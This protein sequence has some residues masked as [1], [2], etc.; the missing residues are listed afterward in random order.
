[1]EKTI[2]KGIL[3]VI[4][5]SLVVPLTFSEEYDYIS[6]KIFNSNDCFV[7]SDNGDTWSPAINPC[8]TCIG[9][10]SYDIGM[11]DGDGSEADQLRKACELPVVSPPLITVDP[12]VSPGDESVDLCP[13]SEGIYEGCPCIMNQNC[14]SDAKYEKFCSNGICEQ[15]LKSEYLE[16]EGSSFADCLTDEFITDKCTCYDSGNINCLDFDQKACFSETCDTE[17]GIVECPPD[18]DC[19]EWGDCVELWSCTPT[20]ICVDGFQSQECVDKAGCEEPQNVPKEIIPCSGQEPPIEEPDCVE[21]T[22]FGTDGKTCYHIKPPECVKNPI[23]VCACVDSS[24][25]SQD[26]DDLTWR[27]CGGACVVTECDDT[28]F[29]REGHNSDSCYTFELNIQTSICE[30]KKV[31][32]SN[33]RGVEG[34]GEC[35]GDAIE[36]GL[37]FCPDIPEECDK[38]GPYRSGNNEYNCYVQEVEDLCEPK[39][40]SVSD[41]LGTMGSGDCEDP[42]FLNQP[43]SGCEKT[44]TDGDGIDDSID[45]CP[46]EGSIGEVDDYGCPCSVEKCDDGNSCTK[47]RC[48]AGKCVYDNIAGSCGEHV[49]CPADTCSTSAPYEFLDYPESGQGQCQAGVC[50]EVN[51]E[52]LSSK[53][54]EECETCQEE[55]EVCDGKDN[56]CNGETDEDLSRQ[57]GS[58]SLGICSFGSETCNDGKWVGCSASFPTQEVC[59]GVDNDCDGAEDNGAGCVCRDGDKKECGISEGACE[60]GEQ[61][62]INGEDWSGCRGGI[63]P[64]LEICDGI[65]NDC[66]GLLDENT[67]EEGSNSIIEQCSINSC[68]GEKFCGLETC[69]LFDDEDSDNLCSE[70]DNCPIDYNPNQEDSDLDGLGNACDFCKND[71]DNDLDNDGV[72]GDQDNC[73]NIANSIQEDSDFDGLG[74]ICDSCVNDPHNDV[75][76]DSICGNLDNCP[77][78]NNPSQGDCDFDG[79]GDACDI[80]SSCSTDSDDDGIMDYYDN[81]PESY[82]FNQDDSD[83]D[84]IG[85]RCDP[86]VNDKYNDVDK[87]GVS[88]EIDNCPLI[89]NE[90]QQ[91]T[92]IDGIGDICDTCDRDKEN[93]RDADNF[94][95]NVD[96]CPDHHNPSQGDCDKDN[97]GD[98]CDFDSICSLDSDKDGINDANDNCPSISNSGQI[99]SDKDNIGDVCD[100]CPKDSFNDQDNDGICGNNDNCPGVLNSN[101]EDKDGDSIGDSCDFCIND[102]QNDID[103]DHICADQDNCVFKAN[104]SQ[105]DC[106]ED[107]LGDACDFDSKCATDKDAD[108][109][110]DLFDNCPENYNP[111]QLDKDGDSI[112][113][114]CDVCPNDPS[115]DLDND[116]S[117][118]DI[119]NCPTVGNLNQL[120]SD[121]DGFGDACDKCPFDTENDLDKDNICG[122]NDNCRYKHNPNQKDCDSNEIGDA[123]DFDSACVEDSDGDGIID[124]EDNCATISNQDQK[125]DDM[126]KIG[127]ACDI[128]PIDILNDLDLDSVCGNNDNCPTLFNPT[129]SN[130]DFDRFGDKCDLCPNDENNDI[131][132]DGICGDVDTC[133]EIKNPNQEE[134][135]KKIEIKEEKYDEEI[136][137]TSNLEDIES[138][139]E[140]S[141]GSLNV[142]EEEIGEYEDIKES[143]KIEKKEFYIDGELYTRYKITIETDNP[144]H[145][146]SYYQNIPKCLAEKTDN[147]FFNGKNYQIIEAD[148]IIAWHF[149]DIEDKV[150]MT[151]DVKGS[152]SE[153]CL[154]DLKDFAYSTSFEKSKKP[155]GLILPIAVIIIV[156]FV[157]LLFEH[158]ISVSDSYEEM[159][160]S[161]V[162]DIKKNYDISNKDNLRTQL[163]N[164]GMNEKYIHEIMKR[165]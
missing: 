91:D 130:Y 15:T 26:C 107:G 84:L 55:S 117:C 49:E 57:C 63:G 81:C 20:S 141:Y 53:I 85:D 17:Y 165:I 5:L 112:G 96:N 54:T 134:D 109:I 64:E 151:Y 13:D 1:M 155:F 66:D 140:D 121:N 42:I 99:D 39:S 34:S 132:E 62:C 124:Y 139:V 116:G 83:G 60:Q 22:K 106:D 156:V 128:C 40:V 52:V 14:F 93:D 152:I 133:P 161:K 7:S 87:D 150:E 78:K 48:E 76:A 90:N 113:D 21:E 6:R 32:R 142:S 123:C 71:P 16:G 114:S 144:M 69:T 162:N 154:E 19:S 153:S 12:E 125:D 72:C 120:N 127:N 131:D 147:I 4:I 74:D 24:Y 44:D 86:F 101:Q 126:D 59:D 119:D 143:I 138:L 35:P 10:P 146:F 98:A 75:D 97:I 157:F 94:C 30:K 164:E 67:D 23:G 31:D 36:V 41:C 18:L 68:D 82:N 70:I 11:F 37:G 92:D 47:A 135:C 108:N 28:G 104:P 163:R 95:S 2:K 61:T 100:L 158:H 103:Q 160:Q 136:T 105:S 110:D 25:P 8:K 149:T 65:D 102:K 38:S 129:Q 46:S 33:C 43:D 29:H 80:E 9:N 159:L 27:T 50:V 58:S 115:N 3:V 51:C 137:V 77:D 118:G 122:N 73:V 79:L 88:G 45:K 145:D 148:P 89:F 111:G 56:N